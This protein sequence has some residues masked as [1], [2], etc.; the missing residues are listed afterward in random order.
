MTAINFGG[1]YLFG[2][3]NVVYLNTTKFWAERGFINWEDTVDSTHGKMTWQ[4][5]LDR[6]KEIRG[7]FGTTTKKLAEKDNSDRASKLKYC[8]D[9]LMLIKR[10]QEQG[11]YDDPT[12]YHHHEI[13]RP[14]S[15]LMS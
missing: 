2:T 10:A 15:F 7:M 13:L 12:C 4:T 11:A 1:V 3:A 14:K 6:V 8:E 5:A 9:M